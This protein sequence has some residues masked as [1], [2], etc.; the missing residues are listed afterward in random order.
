[1]LPETLL[2]GKKH[3]CNGEYKIYKLVN[4]LKECCSCDDLKTCELLINTD[5]PVVTGN[6]Q[7]TLATGRH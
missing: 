6:E 3:R 2:K 7:Q 5:P 1:M 4:C